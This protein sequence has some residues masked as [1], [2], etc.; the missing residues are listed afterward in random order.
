MY[1]LV[2]EKIYK[3]L[4]RYFPKFFQIIFLILNKVD[5]DELEILVKDM[6]F[7]G[8]DSNILEELDQLEN[9]GLKYES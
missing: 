2:K 3:F 8:W 5:S 6:K 4:K 1:R 9:E 7:S